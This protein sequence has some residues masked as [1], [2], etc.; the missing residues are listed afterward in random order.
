MPRSHSLT[1][2]ALLAGLAACDGKDSLP[3]AP[4]LPAA[5]AVSGDTPVTAIVADAAAAIAPSLQIQSDRLG[6]YTNSNTLTSVIQ[7]IGAWVLDSKNPRN[8][9]RK[10]Y[11]DFGQPIAGSGP[12]G[13]A[14][15]AVPSAQ[16][17]FRAI[18]KC[19][20][21]GTS[22]LTLAPSSRSPVPCIWRSI[23]PEARTPSR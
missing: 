15:I 5:N 7:G 16:Y 17:K 4:A 6:A 23:T 9:T 2:I 19:N 1:L 20:L 14:P 12:N 18:S 8:G 3:T 11:L 10:L 21:L 22:F 13:G